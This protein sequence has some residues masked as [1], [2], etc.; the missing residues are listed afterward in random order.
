MKHLGNMKNKLSVFIKIKY[1]N[2][3]KNGIK[4]KCAR[5]FSRRI[6]YK[7]TYFC[8]YLIQ[9]DNVQLRFLLCVVID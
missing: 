3:V 1:L 8:Q 5:K 7:Q 6:S 4:K 2:N 9:K